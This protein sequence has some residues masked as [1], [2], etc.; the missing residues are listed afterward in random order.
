MDKN[1]IEYLLKINKSDNIFNLF[2]EEYLNR[3]YEQ[4]NYIKFYKMLIKKNISK[5]LAHKI[6]DKFFNEGLKA[7]S[8]DSCNYYSENNI[9]RIKINTSANQISDINFT[10]IIK[11]F[12]KIVGN[13]CQLFHIQDNEWN[14]TILDVS[15]G[16][17]DIKLG[18]NIDNLDINLVKFSDKTEEKIVSNFVEILTNKKLKDFININ[19]LIKSCITAFLTKTTNVDLDDTV[20]FIDLKQTKKEKR[21]IYKTIKKLPKFESVIM[22]DETVMAENIDLII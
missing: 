4:Y 15:S 21:K 10:K 7:F 19:D 8:N 13:F 12:K 16:C 6:I 17:L 22:N 1:T 11:S 5:D 3:N 9:F 14:L 2:Y 18:I 20:K